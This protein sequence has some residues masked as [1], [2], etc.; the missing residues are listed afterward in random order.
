MEKKKTIKVRRY[1]KLY[2]E[3]KKKEKKQAFKK[4]EKK[5]CICHSK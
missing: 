4:K 2:L 5:T 1:C 3:R